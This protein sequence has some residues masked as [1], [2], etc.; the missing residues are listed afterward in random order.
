MSYINLN[1]IPDYLLDRK[2][3]IIFWTRKKSDVSI[4]FRAY[5]IEEKREEYILLDKNPLAE[6]YVF[7][8]KES[9]G[10]CMGMIKGESLQHFKSKEDAFSSLSLQLKDTL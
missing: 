2:D 8:S 5:I 6:V 4:R 10:S 7:A 9:H 1:N 3:P